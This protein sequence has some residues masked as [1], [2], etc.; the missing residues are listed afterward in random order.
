MMR[1]RTIINGFTLTEVLLSLA[2]FSVCL[3]GI[4]GLFPIALQ[5][6]KESQNLSTI[7][8]ITKSSMDNIVNRR[9]FVHPEMEWHKLP[10]SSINMD[11]Q[12][13]EC[14]VYY[15]GEPPGTRTG[16]QVIHVRTEWV[17]LRVKKEYRLTGVMLR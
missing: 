11:G 16:L 14:D 17:H 10:L 4:I 7:A 15:M 3:L 1:R 2:I 6:L 5:N 12:G 9:E 8:L 13:I